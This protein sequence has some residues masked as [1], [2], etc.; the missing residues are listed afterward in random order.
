M[1]IAAI[2]MSIEYFDNII[3]F[4]TRHDILELC[5]SSSLYLGWSDRSKLGNAADDSNKSIPCLHSKW[6]EERI[7]RSDILF[8]VDDCI[9][10]TSWFKYKNLNKVILN[11][12]RTDD[13][14]YI[15]VHPNEFA[16]LY[17]VNLDWKDGWY[18]ETLFYNPNNLDEIIHT[19][20][21]K[22]GRIILFDGEI[23]HAIRPQ[24]SNA[25]K[26]RLSL[27]LFFDDGKH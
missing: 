15:H 3:P 5:L 27:T 23:P 6:T 13:V 1:G 18:G 24:S 2:E 11:V 12:V 10:K 19:S 21:Y 16:V 9:Q 22:P 26:Y 8:Y 7:N 17:Y 4:K 25:P 14:H 20:I